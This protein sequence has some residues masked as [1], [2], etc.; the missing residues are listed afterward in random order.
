[1]IPSIYIH[2]VSPFPCG[3]ARLKAAASSTPGEPVRRYS[4]GVLHAGNA[5]RVIPLGCEVR[6]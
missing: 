5:Q 4:L 1:M 2:A 3:S 6:A